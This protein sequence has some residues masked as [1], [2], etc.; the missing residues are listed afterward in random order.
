MKESILR[1]GR[2]VREL[3]AQRVLDAGAA[4]CGEASTDHVNSVSK[5]PAVMRMADIRG[6]PF[7]PLPAGEGSGSSSEGEDNEG[8]VSPSS[9][10][11]SFDDN[12]ESRA[13][14]EY[15]DG[16]SEVFSLTSSIG[17]TM[18][19]SMDSM[20]SSSDSLWKQSS[21]CDT[22]NASVGL[23]LLR[24]KAADVKPVDVIAELEAERAS[25]MSAY[26][27]RYET[28][29]SARAKASIHD[30]LTTVNMEIVAAK[31]M[32]L[33]YADPFEGTF[34]VLFEYAH[35]LG[36]GIETFANSL[37]Q[38]AAV[39]GV[40]V[41]ADAQRLHG[42]C[43][44]M[45]VLWAGAMSEK[46]DVLNGKGLELHQ[47]LV[48]LFNR[49]GG[50]CFAPLRALCEALHVSC[51]EMVERVIAVVRRD[52]K[53]GYCQHR[54]NSVDQLV[55]GRPGRMLRSKDPAAE[56]RY[57][58]EVDEALQREMLTRA[59]EGEFD[60]VADLRGGELAF[61]PYAEGRMVTCSADVA[62][63]IHASIH[64]M[65]READVDEVAAAQ[66]RCLMCPA[67]TPG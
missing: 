51:E 4:D 54:D 55:A 6:G 41:P 26:R 15:H 12:G 48:Y 3:R 65:Y 62:A 13:D 9:A 42:Q 20:M 5:R 21:D 64:T 23:E 16:A 63:H 57:L 31:A 43:V 39:A 18:S 7:S 52:N 29:L 22:A 1:V 61:V 14:C 37:Y 45:A 2:E 49:H 27:A 32:F 66:L 28:T 33:A 24:L 60:L 56:L 46:L 36:H 35:T 34:A 40:A 50:F 19:G 53:K 58:V 30:F 67:M 11:S 8:Q 44:G 47:S 10:S 17:S 25:L 38:R 59:F